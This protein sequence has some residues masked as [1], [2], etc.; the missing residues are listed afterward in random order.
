MADPKNIDGSGK[1]PDVAVAVVSPESSK[2]TSPAQSPKEDTREWFKSLS[3]SERVVFLGI[4]DKRT[5]TGLFRL[6]SLSGE[7]SADGPNFEGQYIFYASL[8][9]QSVETCSR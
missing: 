1:Q 8:R 9:R 4:K 7:R 2:A 6:A 3:P 5:I